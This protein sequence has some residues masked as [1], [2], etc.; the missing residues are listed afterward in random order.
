MK[1]ISLSSMPLNFIGLY[2]L[3]Y[4]FFLVP[5]FTG[6][7]QRG[8][9]CDDESITMEFKENTISIPQLLIASILAC[10]VTTLICEWYV[11]LTDKTVETEKYNYRNYNIPPFLIKALTFFGY[12]HIGFIAQLGLIQVPKYS[13]GRLRPHFLDVCQPTGYNCA[14]PHQ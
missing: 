7:Y 10:I 4:T 3:G 11:S 14:F 9:Y 1:T 6:T 13:V 2:A 5:E 8:F 12:S